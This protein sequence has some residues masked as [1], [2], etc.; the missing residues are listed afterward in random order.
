[1]RSR[2]PNWISFAAAEP[3][4]CFLYHDRRDA[5]T[6]A[7]GRCCVQRSIFSPPWTRLPRQIRRTI[8]SNRTPHLRNHLEMAMRIKP[9]MTGE[10]K[11]HW[12]PRVPLDCGYPSMLTQTRL[13]RPRTNHT[14][15]PREPSRRSSPRTRLRTQPRT[16]QP[17]QILPKMAPSTRTDR[18]RMIHQNR[19]RPYVTHPG[20]KLFPRRC[21]Q[22]RNNLSNS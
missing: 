5:Y 18:R 21:N 7:G 4:L 15:T 12:R 16:P 10:H 14:T 13:L 9:F 1:M 6:F 3:V 11:T 20:R 17:G 8:A 22:C 2:V 19:N